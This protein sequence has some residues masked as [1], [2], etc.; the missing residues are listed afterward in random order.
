M[1]DLVA[2]GETPLRLSPPGS[3]RVE[4]AG[5]L[6][7][8]ADGTESNV[9]VAANGLGSDALW[10]SKIRDSAVGRNAVRQ[11]EATGLDTSI[12]WTADDGRQ[13]IMFRESGAAPRRSRCW[14]DRGHT[15]F[16]T[17]EPGEFPVE[18]IQQA[19]VIYTGLTSA[20]LSEQCTDT[21]EALLRA[22]GG[23]GA[24]TALE[25]DYEPELAT[26]RAYEETFTQLSDE[27]DVLITSENAI[28][29]VLG[30]H[31]SSRE[32]TNVLAALY[33]LQI[34][35]VRRAD[36]SAIVLQD[37]P[38]TNVIHERTMVDTEVVDTM[39]EQG[40]FTGAFLHELVQG[41][42]SA[43]ALTRAVASAAFARTTA[44][45]FL[46]TDDEELEPV[47]EQVLEQS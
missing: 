19:R 36:G 20:T 3:E 18:T 14:H 15:A 17:A 2:F 8:Y 32:L 5:S 1:V 47:I 43:R 45:P 26:A 23:S 16:A 37:S 24:V 46:T 38:G 13:G 4:M 6:D 44:G 41:S 12:T 11:I 34:V 40:A 30:E 35:V 42:D 39:G 21:T 27:V 33:D 28:P 29:A 7:V 31:G 25:L 22:G 10:V 9:A